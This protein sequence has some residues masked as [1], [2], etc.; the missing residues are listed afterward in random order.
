MITEFKLFEKH[1]YE[2][3]DIVYCKL[4]PSSGVFYTNRPYEIVK[5]EENDHIQVKDLTNGKEIMYWVLM[6][7]FI[8]EYEYIAK[9]YNL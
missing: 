2:I 9:R 1:N 3:G 6:D 7:R 8:P 5:L 4:L